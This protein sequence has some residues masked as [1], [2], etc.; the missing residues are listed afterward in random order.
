[1]KT[2]AMDFIINFNTWTS[3]HLQ[4]GEKVCNKCAGSGD[5]LNTCDS[6]GY[7]K[8]CSKCKGKG[9]VTWLENIFNK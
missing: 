9:K 2:D 6:D 7:C 5:D 8:A 1:M 4:P 3:L